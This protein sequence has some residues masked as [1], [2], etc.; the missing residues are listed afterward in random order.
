MTTG[1]RAEL[2]IDA[3]AECPVAA[4]S[5]R[6]G[7]EFRDVTWTGDGGTVVEEFRGDASDADPPDVDRV[8][9]YR[10]E[11]VYQIERTG[12]GRCPCEVI[13]GLNVPTGDV[14][15]AD[16]SLYVT[17]HLPSADRVREVIERLHDRGFD[18]SVQGLCRTVGA[19][20]ESA[21]TFVDRDTLTERQAEVV[22]TAY[23][24]G[25]FE[26]PRATNAERVAAELDIHP[27]T[28]AEHLATAQAKLLD[29]I[30]G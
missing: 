12:D 6:A 24:M 13:E 29:Q 19:A 26:Y 18:A 22:E 5:E 28:L 3:A 16:G 2:R 7:A 17:V 25:Y 11:S 15:A 21:A 8:F 10:N 9:E 1:L 27:S 23:E 14:R 4:F 20:D 30:V